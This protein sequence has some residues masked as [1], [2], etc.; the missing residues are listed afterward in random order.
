MYIYIY[1]YIYI[2]TH[3]YYVSI[4]NKQTGTVIGM[5]YVNEQRNMKTNPSFYQ[6]PLEEYVGNSGTRG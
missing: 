3:N 6:L 2:Y 5:G 1:I 4:K